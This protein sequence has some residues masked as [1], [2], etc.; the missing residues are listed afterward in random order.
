MAS[1]IF[2]KWLIIGI[3][4][5]IFLINLF[6]YALFYHFSPLL[7]SS[8]TTFLVKI[9]GQQSFPKWGFA[10]CIVPSLVSFS[11]VILSAQT[12]N[13]FRKAFFH[14][15]AV[16]AAAL[17]SVTFLP[18]N[19]PIWLNYLFFMVVVTVVTILRHP[20]IYEIA[21]L[22]E[23]KNSF[24]AQKT[25]LMFRMIHN[26]LLAIARE[27]LWALLTGVIGAGIAM[28]TYLSSIAGPIIQQNPDLRIFFHGQTIFFGVLLI[29]GMIIWI[30]GGTSFCFNR[31]I[32]V[33]KQLAK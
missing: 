24:S 15:F 32:A 28:L 23:S 16:M 12:K 8:E 2:D 19:I 5:G 9:T 33:E 21:H 17:F 1:R 10:L 4:V 27:S 11:I 3:M 20:S 13:V 29:W 18:V 14:A 6:F 30:I 31:L 25:M 26:R 7:P 22:K